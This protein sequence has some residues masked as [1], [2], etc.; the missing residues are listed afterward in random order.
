MLFFAAHGYNLVIATVAGAEVRRS[1][2]RYA[3]VADTS[4]IVSEKF[5]RIRYFG[6]SRIQL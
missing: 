4:V 1:V 5:F 2:W 6:L 3:D